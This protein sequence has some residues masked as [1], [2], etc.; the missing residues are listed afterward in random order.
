M[1]RVLRPALWALPFTISAGLLA[2]TLFPK[3]SLAASTYYLYRHPTASYLTCGWHVNACYDYPTPVASGWA[4]DWTDAVPSSGFYVYFYTK[5][6]TG[7]SSSWAGT[8]AVGAPG[9]STCFHQTYVVIRDVTDNWQ[10][11][12]K[13]THTVR[14]YFGSRITIQ[15]GLFPQT[16]SA[17]IGE[18]ADEGSCSTW[19]G[20]HVHEESGG[21]WPNKLNYP[22]EDTCNWPYKPDE[23]GTYNIDAYP[24]LGTSW[25]V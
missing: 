24:M 8:G 2:G 14:T 18:T 10:A 11:D 4:L 16:T 23:C 19:S 22:D 25:T 1:S 3:T 5:S 12:A 17:I 9:S 7:G 13:Y 20:H 6:N 21:G 15:T